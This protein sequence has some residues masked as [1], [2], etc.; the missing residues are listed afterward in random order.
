MN[1]TLKQFAQTLKNTVKWELSSNI[2][3]GLESAI[4]GAVSY[5]KNLNTSLTNIRIVTG[6][7]VEDMAKFAVEANKAARALS[8]TTKAYADASL[9]YYQQGD[10]VEQAAK[11]AEITLK[12]ANASFNTSAQE[13][14]EYLTAVWNSYQVGAEELERYVDIMAALGAKTA[15]SLEEIATSMQKVAATANTV[16][17]S[18]EQVSSIV[19]TVSSVTRESAESIGTSYKTIFARIGDLKLGETLDDGVTLGQVSSQ[20]DKIGVAIL[21]ANGDMRDMGDIIE[22]LGS[23]WQTM[24]RAEQTAIAQV[25]AGKRQYTQLMA[26]FENWDM[27][28]SNIN[29]AETSGGALQEMQDTY[30]ES[31]KAASDQV[32]A[33]LENIY[34]KI[35]N[36][37]AIIKFTKGISDAIDM[38]GGLIDAF[39]GIGG[40]LGT[41]GSIGIKVF[42]KQI[43]GSIDK[44][45][46]KITTY[47]GQFNGIKDA[48][49]QIGKGQSKNVQ[50]L[51]WEKAR[52]DIDKNFEKEK[53]DLAK[54]G[55][56]TT[57]ISYAQELLTYKQQLVNIEQELST[58]EKNS[59][60]AAIS[61]L[62][63]Q[64]SA[65]LKLKEDKKELLELSKQQAK[66][67][68]NAVIMKTSDK[69]GKN[70][71]DR[72]QEVSA[73]IQE[74][75]EVLNEIS[76][77]KHI[78]QSDATSLDALLD[79][80]ES[81]AKKSNLIDQL[82]MNIESGQDDVDLLKKKIEELLGEKIEAN[83]VKDLQKKLEELQ[84][85]ANEA[86]DEIQE[87]LDI[88]FTSN[89][90]QEGQ[91]KEAV[92]QAWQNAQTR[93]Q[94]KAS[95]EYE[96]NFKE[97]SLKKARKTLQDLLNPKSEAYSKLSKN[98]TLAG[99]AASSLTSGLSIGANLV[100]T[101]SDESATLGDKLS[102]AAGGLTSLVSSFATGGWV[103]LAVNV[104]GMVISGIS[105]AKK[106]REE[107]EKRLNQEK[108]DFA[109]KE[110]DALLE[111]Q[112][113]INSLIETYYQLEDSKKVLTN[114]EYV[115]NV[116]ELTAALAGETTT[117]QG[118]IAKYGDLD[119]AVEKMRLQKLQ[120]TRDQLQAG[121]EPQVYAEETDFIDT[122]KV[123][124]NNYYALE[125]RAIADIAGIVQQEYARTLSTED[126]S[127]VMIEALTKTLRQAEL[128]APEI[129]EGSDLAIYKDFF[130][131]ASGG[132]SFFDIAQSALENSIQKATNENINWD[133]GFF[134]DIL[135]EQLMS[136]PHDEYLSND[137]ALQMMASLTE[138]LVRQYGDVDTQQQYGIIDPSQISWWS[139]LDTKGMK[140]DDFEQDSL[141]ESIYDS[142]SISNLGNTKM[143]IASTDALPEDIASWIQELQTGIWTSAEEFLAFYQNGK[144][145][146][147]KYPNLK[148]NTTFTEWFNGLSY[149][150]NYGEVV[151]QIQE[152][153]AELGLANKGFTASAFSN[154]TD[155]TAFADQAEKAINYLVNEQ[156]Y[157]YSAAKEKVSSLVAGWGILPDI[158]NDFN[159]ILDLA[160]FIASQ[161]GANPEEVKTHLENFYSEYD[162]DVF[163]SINFGAIEYTP[164]QGFNQQQLLKTQTYSA[165]IAAIE[166][167]NKSKVA[168]K[169]LLGLSDEE[170]KALSLDAWNEMS[171]DID[172]KTIE[173]SSI[174]SADDWIKTANREDREKYLQGIIEAEETSMSRDNGILETAAQASRT[175]AESLNEIYIAATQDKN[176]KYILDK[177]EILKRQATLEALSDD[178]LKN[179]DFTSEDIVTKYKDFGYT[180]ADIEWLKQYST[181][182]KTQEGPKEEDKTR[183]I[184]MRNVHQSEINTRQGY[185]SY[186]D[187]LPSI[188]AG[189]IQQAEGYE[190]EKT[191]LENTSQFTDS[192]PIDTFGN[193]IKVLQENLTNI[194]SDF[195]ELNSIDVSAMPTEGSKAYKALS[196]ALQATGKSIND[197]T[198][199]TSKIDKLN[200]LKEAKNKQL[201]F[202]KE[203]QNAIAMAYANEN[204]FSNETTLESVLA[205]N[206]EKK[207]VAYQAWQEALKAQAELDEKIAQV[208]TETAEDITKINATEFDAQMQS[209]KKDLEKT[210]KDAENLKQLSENL[211]SG[212]DNGELD[213]NS[214][215]TM[216]DKG[217]GTKEEWNKSAEE[218]AKITAKAISAAFSAEADIVIAE[219]TKLDELLVFDFDKTELMQSF[220]SEDKFKEW[221]KNLDGLSN[222]AKNI[223]SEMYNDI[224]ATLGEDFTEEDIVTAMTS[225]FTN[226]VE[227]GKISL[228]ELGGSFKD[229]Y[230]GII[231]QMAEA[232]KT[233]TQSACDA[234][235]KAFNLIKDARQGLASG[236]SLAEM[237][238]GDVESIYELMLSATDSEAFKTNFYRTD[239]SIDLTQ[240]EWNKNSQ[241]ASRGL[242]LLTAAD[243]ETKHTTWD[244]AYQD[245]MTTIGETTKQ[246]LIDM[247]NKANEG[248]AEVDKLSEE[249]ISAQVDADLQT[250]FKEQMAETLQT[251]FPKEDEKTISERLDRLFAGDATE[252]E[253][254]SSHLDKFTS[255]VDLAGESL[256]KIAQYEEAK[257][258]RDMEMQTAEQAV[259]DWE[260]QSDEQ[261]GYAN[262]AGTLFQRAD[263]KPIISY[264]GDTY[265]EEEYLSVVNDALA[266]MKKQQVNSLEQI[267]HETWG[268]LQLYFTE[269]SQQFAQKAAEAGEA[270]VTAGNTFKTTV[271]TIF[272][273]GSS[274][275]VS[276]GQE[277]VILEEEQTDRV[278]AGKIDMTTAIGYEQVQFNLDQA[279]TRQNAISG[280]LDAST[281][282][283]MASAADT[284]REAYAG[285]DKQ[286]QQWVEDLIKARKAG[287]DGLEANK[288]LTSQHIKG[289]KDLSKMNKAQREQYKTMLDV[290]KVTVDGYKDLKSYFK[291][292]DDVGEAIDEMN[293]N[294]E[295]FSLD[296]Y[297]DELSDSEI[298]TEEMAKMIKEF[299]PES[300]QQAADEIAAIAGDEH[301][302]DIF[303]ALSDWLQDDGTFTQ[304]INDVLT[305][306]GLGADQILAAQQSVINQIQNGASA[307]TID[308]LQVFAD[309]NVDPT[310]FDSVLEF[311]NA[312]MAAVQQDLISRGLELTLPWTPI[313]TLSERGV[314]RG[315]GGSGGGRKPSSSGGGGGGSDNKKKEDKLRFKD[316][317]ERY[318]V[319]NEVLD[320]TSEK[321][322]KISKQ[323]ERAYGS[324][325]VDMLNKETE[326][327]WEQY[328]AQAALANEANKWQASDK[329]E[330]I[331]LGVGVEFDKD[332]NISNYEEV[333]QALIDQYN[334]EVER[335]NNSDQGDGD[336][337]RLDDA[338]ER[339]EDA[340]QAIEDYEEAI[341]TANDALNEM[342]EIQ[343]Q[344]S[345]NALEKITY[346]LDLKI[347]L[348]ENDLDFLE[349]LQNK[350]DDVLEDQDDLFASLMNSATEYTSNLAAVNEAFA[351]LE[352]D[353][354]VGIINDA[355]YAE[356]LSE[357]N[358]LLLENLNNLEDVKD[359]LA[360]IYSDTLAKAREEI[361]YAT[362]ALDH[363]NST[364]ESYIT[365]AGLAGE[366]FFTID[367]EIIDNRYRA[368]E[369][370]YDSQYENNLK[371]LNIQK[372]HLDALLEQ[373]AVFR[374]KLESGEEL[375]D[376]ERKQYEALA[377]EI[378]N[379]RDELLS[380]TQATMEAVRAAY[381]NTIN[382]IAEDL[383]NFMAGSATSLSH[384]QQQYDYFQEQQ[385]RYVSTAQELYE[386]SKLNRDIENSLATA[387]SDAAKEA[388]KALQE[389]INKQSELNEL[390]EY[391]IQMNQLEYQL[392]LARIQLEEA[393]NAKDVVR[394]TRDENGNYAYRYTANQDKVNEAVQQYEDT[395]QQIND[396]TVQRTSEIESQMIAA[397]Q[398]YT[399]RFN[400][401]NTDYTLS[402]EERNALLAEL[403]EEF[404]ETMTY[405]QE[406]SAI[407]T[408]N[409][410]ANQTAIAQHYGVALSQI[411]ESTAGN[412]NANIQSMLENTQELIDAMNNA[413]F[414]EDGA[415]TAWQELQERLGLVNAASGTAYGDM[416]S[417]AEDMAEMNVFAA[418]EALDVLTILEETI[419][420]LNDLTDAW[421]SHAS[422]LEN[423]I[424]YYEDLIKAINQAATAA[425]GFNT[426]TPPSS[427][428]GSAGTTPES[429]TG[430]SGS[431]SGTGTGTRSKNNSTTDFNFDL[432]DIDIFRETFT[433]FLNGE[434]ISEADK[435][436]L[437]TNFNAV[438]D[439]IDSMTSELQFRAPSSNNIN[440][441]NS[442]DSTMTQNIVI[443]ADFPNVVDQDEIIA[444]FLGLAD[445]AQQLVNEQN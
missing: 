413:I 24:S 308:W 402:T 301:K 212:I 350:Y 190:A 58:A 291:M 94:Q 91:E 442:S 262:M 172:W 276:A 85:E 385:S 311:L 200:L 261:A 438:L 134:Y 40:V 179:T 371:K 72:K 243:G 73:N 135:E 374:E 129:Q 233:A 254:V 41:L 175:Y 238:A 101:M 209:V 68:V 140:L 19:A 388:L 271:E 316:E 363:F 66:E 160:E 382:A 362:D 348:N 9:I 192:K 251:L 294:V 87:I 162:R 196:S 90:E 7:S 399:A 88:S 151:T 191:F 335:F 389:K 194:Q 250:K 49:S 331:S 93:G 230:L 292:V 217:Y 302:G 104:V 176:S 147:D 133:L 272:G 61:G 235:I 62:S 386:V 43:M 288:K 36:D 383:D 445:Q 325:Y 354:A 181:S 103:G 111:E 284:L 430:T 48:F 18:M 168:A 99:E 215:Q 95:I 414:G 297:N 443:N 425:S 307:G 408:G 287:K 23:K 273:T 226:A 357:L 15:T 290:N 119:T 241:L 391:D 433:S 263:N 27:Y 57:A 309:A 439:Y 245:W 393:Q 321:L 59:V 89:T 416:I 376:L 360:E 143:G 220:A 396:L 185:V 330:L 10:S 218:R 317:T 381:E 267:D 384:L 29:I 79:K 265:S 375:S 346:K 326:A 70:W 339:Y 429:N 437:R 21:D 224:S 125:D 60:N 30:A 252:W 166:T 299:L 123:G 26:L 37:Q 432:D 246:N 359:E 343:N 52:G 361:E 105:E 364:M 225:A 310:Q 127:S 136:L 214:M 300:M 324:K 434:A 202:E 344:I 397:M 333:M 146:M 193:S 264:L 83:T 46:G 197:Y 208:N 13:M 370:F 395:L 56:D 100:S 38:V 74:G 247:Y 145:L 130:A 216:I 289:A 67:D 206:D 258:I 427:G 352:A 107:E 423:L 313:K 8:T 229:T 269:S 69:G 257:A 336:Q 207:L 139:N 278:N 409:L 78:K 20:L 170:I 428:S 161:T 239:N 14:S 124:S 242:N 182:L 114:S 110:T 255:S 358:D 279:D 142:F 285:A 268:E 424:T 171:A 314:G 240:Q 1:N 53:I 232:E 323:K 319:Q 44:T 378:R 199:A 108:A 22:D 419:E 198:N 45:V 33:S 320:R 156:G 164:G 128:N 80:S 131:E 177:Q 390:T 231:E 5:A 106:L 116:L 109:K 126:Q 42:E 436:N 444:A 337:L 153:D 144:E 340:K 295:D 441:S 237:Y 76:P 11:K 34:N 293:E 184:Q 71:N 234:W 138:T 275:A 149:L 253:T 137:Y 380:S 167:S 266:Q 4:S 401:I 286:T 2:V 404:S 305:T 440:S 64:Q 213:I 25:V 204:N 379:T 248:K 236:K 28:Q 6:Q 115:Q 435:E 189:L 400:E 329:A 347:E 86:Q 96:L 282:E 65:V 219:K 392:L 210:K 280:I 31:W 121:L 368:L 35:I 334:A 32:T 169:T 394:L 421:D 351:Q 98:L 260:K 274:Q 203:K 222:E 296:N 312:A 117:I 97:S 141:L 186:I 306:M 63:Q 318:H 256:L 338:K 113:A 259:N 281:M 420:P 249:Q 47:F 17:V 12:A 81:I 405:L 152:I 163:S 148:T 403:Q 155:Y 154:I 82:L 55:H 332:G 410:T 303:S 51:E 406:Q 327:L 183:I 277:L 77:L 122:G 367:G 244:A 165:N 195:S 173:G 298:N 205:E 187:N 178:V 426:D 283:E 372:A 407:A 3:H 369:T 373:E 315:G 355:D 387:T 341:K 345:E 223:F 174:S 188:R 158:A 84:Q 415:N 180:E 201:E 221:L 50:Q 112:S 92:F 356:G 150:E 417:S 328:N 304:S 159:T 228:E 75:Y 157:D 118:L 16:G 120:E 411:T 398:E 412:V 422:T 431:N 211:S 365:I 353:Y 342:E 102:V 366:S 322:D 418:Q 270:I 377:E 349:Y 39:G 132:K 54:E 227:E